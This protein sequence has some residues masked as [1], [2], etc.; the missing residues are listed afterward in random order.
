MRILKV[1][2]Q[3]RNLKVLGA[4]EQFEGFGGQ[5]RNLKVWGR[6]RN[7][8]GRSAWQPRGS[9]E[10]KAHPLGL[11]V[12]APKLA[13]LAFGRDSTQQ[14]DLA[15]G[16]LYPSIQSPMALPH[17]CTHLCIL[18][19]NGNKLERG[20]TDMYGHMCIGMYIHIYIYIYIWTYVCTHIRI[21]LESE[22]ERQ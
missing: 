20:C 17:A 9:D 16:I 22:R 11:G 18:A 12:H 14:C 4:S 5:V 1:L 7:W 6:V 21:H 13:R 3:V 2:G 19:S 8:K 15:M 10:V